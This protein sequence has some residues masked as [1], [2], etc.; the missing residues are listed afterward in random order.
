MALLQKV[1]KWNLATEK[2]SKF[3]FEEEEVQYYQG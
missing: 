3:E 1:L 2:Y